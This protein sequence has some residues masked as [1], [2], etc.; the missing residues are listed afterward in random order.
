MSNAVP[1]TEGTSVSTPKQPLDP[2]LKA[3]ENESH[4]YFFVKLPQSS[5]VP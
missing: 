2:H 4:P 1:E 3:L 5:S